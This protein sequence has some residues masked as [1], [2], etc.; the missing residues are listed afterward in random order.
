MTLYRQTPQ[1][2]FA[3]YEKGQ[4]IVK[5]GWDALSS[6]ATTWFNEGKKGQSLRLLEKK[7]ISEK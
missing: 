1:T 3:Q 2:Y 4:L 6:W 5:D 7:Q